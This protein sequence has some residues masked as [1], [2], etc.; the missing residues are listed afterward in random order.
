MSFTALVLA[1]PCV[2]EAERIALLEAL[3]QSH[4]DRGDAARLLGMD[5]PT[6]YAKLKEHDLSS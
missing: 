4:G 5:R 2:S 1:S 6:F 3:N